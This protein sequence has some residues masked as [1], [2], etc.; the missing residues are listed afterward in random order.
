MTIFIYNLK[1][2]GIE[3][4]TNRIFLEFMIGLRLENAEFKYELVFQWKSKQCCIDFS[5]EE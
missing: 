1:L 5:K 3:I 4:I 2:F